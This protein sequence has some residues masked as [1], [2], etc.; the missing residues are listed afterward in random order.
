MLDS[1]E[2]TFWAHIEYTPLYGCKRYG[3]FVSPNCATV[4]EFSTGHVLNKTHGDDR[5][6]K[7]VEYCVE[8]LKFWDR[9]IY[10]LWQP[11][12]KTNWASLEQD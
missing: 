5:E 10:V 4:V 7:A 3:V 6:R 2:S 9:G 1:D 12:Y 11:D 8:I